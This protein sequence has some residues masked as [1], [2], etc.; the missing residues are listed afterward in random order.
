MWQP[1]S[2]FCWRFINR[3][4][5]FRNDYPLGVYIERC[6]FLIHLTRS[7]LYE[8]DRWYLPL[9]C[10]EIVIFYRYFKWVDVCVIVDV[11]GTKCLWT[12][13]WALVT[14][15]LLTVASISASVSAT[16]RHHRR[17][18]NKRSL[19]DFISPVSPLHSL[20][21]FPW[22]FVC[23]GQASCQASLSPFVTWLVQ[24]SGAR[25][26]RIGLVF[27]T[28]WGLLLVWPARSRFLNDMCWAR[29]CSVRLQ[30]WL[31]GCKPPYT[32]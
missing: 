26:W 29:R 28:V 27:N 9:K 5:L 4:C 10:V 20:F 13:R 30:S 23:L 19:L 6:P 12:G 32:V 8:A 24:G 1:L 22:L 21:V 15:I 16:G 25:L 7:S 2:R 18:H 11:K 17:C 31:V 14:L 3:C